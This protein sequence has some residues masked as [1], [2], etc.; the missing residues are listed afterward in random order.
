ML[1]LV[2]VAIVHLVIVH[3]SSVLGRSSLETATERV[4]LVLEFFDF[5]LHVAYDV[6]SPG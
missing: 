5:G 3:D 1:W 6:V 2:A 4:P